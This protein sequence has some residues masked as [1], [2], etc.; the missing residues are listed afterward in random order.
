MPKMRSG[1]FDQD[2]YV[3]DYQRQYRITKLVTF[4]RKIEDDMTMLQWIEGQPESFV[5]YVKRL[6]KQDMSRFD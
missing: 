6:I 2:Q 5:Q 3:K 4:N 1:N